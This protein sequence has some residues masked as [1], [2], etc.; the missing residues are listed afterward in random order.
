MEDVYPHGGT[1]NGGLDILVGLLD[2]HFDGEGRFS[3]FLLWW[4]GVFAR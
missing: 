2:E 4:G 3:A 1:G